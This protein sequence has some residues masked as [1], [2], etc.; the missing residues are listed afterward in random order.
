MSA[1]QAGLGGQ[2]PMS[3]IRIDS[4]VQPRAQM[5]WIVVAEY[6]EAMK[7]GDTFP[8]VVVFHDGDA[9]WLADGF[10]R[11][12][13]A[14]D[15]AG[16]TEFP[17]DVRQGCKRDA[18]LYALGA[19]KAHGMRMTN[20]DKR[21]VVEGMLG[22]AE[23]VQWADREI[24]RH[25][26]VSFM[27]V[28]RHRE[29]ICNNVVDTKP[30]TQKT[31]RKVTRKGKTYTQDTTN[32]GKPVPQPEPEPPQGTLY[33]QSDETPTE[34]SPE[35]HNDIPAPR[36]VVINGDA[37][38][39]SQHVTDPA[40]L[41]IT[42]P[43][44]NV[45][46]DYDVHSDDISTYIP[47]VTAVWRECY[48]VM[49]GGARIAVVVPF[50]LGRNPYIPFDCQIM[51]TLIDAGFTLRGRIVWDKNTTGNRATWGSFRLPTDPSLRDTT[52]AIIVAH[53]GQ[54]NLEI[55]VENRLKDDKG[56]HTAWL[57][58]SDYFMA[59]AQDHW[60]IAPESAQRV[61]HPAPFPP[62]L[63]RRLIHFYGFPGC[64]VIDPFGGSGTVGVVAK[65]LGC[66]A[67]LFEISQDY[68]RLAEERIRG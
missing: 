20:A 36:V 61:K 30:S 57:A 17:A 33:E 62:E 15:Y 64:H 28:G 65:E 27:T 8:P 16:L 23:W 2:L 39:L 21:R 32:I 5:D 35:P 56:T 40:H 13:A 3:L 42:S 29:S 6:A 59:M 38:Y 60:Q 67:T 47:L 58:D 44:Y 45:G 14:R 63:V 50:G 18:W 46:I 34:P 7:A 19:N 66:Q 10:H 51:Q 9:Y 68:S 1:P 37:Q 53:K 26:G 11:I 41:I 4:S 25:C 55:P 31:E 24:A 22:D 48:K 12:S 43:P 54:S 49:V 52:E